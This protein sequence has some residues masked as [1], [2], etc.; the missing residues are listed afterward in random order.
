M[1]SLGPKSDLPIRL[2]IQNVGFGNM[3]KSRPVT[4]VLRKIEGDS[5]GTP[6]EI[7]QSG[8][9]DPQTI[10]SR[11]V[12][13][14]SPFD[15][16]GNIEDYNNIQAETAFDGMNEIRLEAK[17]PETLSEGDYAVFL[18]IS[19]YGNWPAD[20]NYSTV[21]FA[22][23]SAYFDKLTGSNYIGKFTL[24]EK[25]P[26][27]TA[28]PEFSRKSSGIQI[29]FSD[30]SLTVQNA[31]RI[32]IFDLTGHRFLT[33]EVSTGEETVSLEKL[34]RGRFIARAFHGQKSKSEILNS[35]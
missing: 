18:R 10:R 12:E 5:Y 28:V 22:N 32:E 33:K 29:F 26:T 21:R 6:V 17:L 25:A 35:R 16:D 30:K 13:L 9:F 15:E 11:T 19:Q 1:D 4:I 23:D 8:N 24:S 7:K 31:D 3:T 14:K 2:K 27:F 20:S 34:P